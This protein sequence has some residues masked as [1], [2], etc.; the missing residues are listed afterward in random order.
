MAIQMVPWRARHA[1]GRADAARGRVAPP[2]D[3]RR[4]MAG[5]RGKEWII[6]ATICAWTN[7]AG[8]GTGVAEVLQS[9]AGESGRYRFARRRTG[10]LSA[11]RSAGAA[12]AADLGRRLTAGV[13]AQESLSLWRE[14]YQIA[15]ERGRGLRLRLHIDSW[16][17]ARLP[18]E[19]LYDTRRGDFYVFD[20]MISLVRYVRLPAAPP[21]LRQSRTLKVLARWPRPSTSRPSIGT[22]V[23][24]PA[25]CPARS[26]RRRTGGAGHLLTPHPGTPAPGPGRAHAGRD[27]L[28]RPRRISAGSAPGPADAGE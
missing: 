7:G 22:R 16:D 1:A 20:P 24:L 23:G 4:P 25:R 8:R 3:G 27:P 17:L 2:V 18:W 5:H 14:S 26:R 21:A 6:S 19:L 9:P 10:P 12:L 11:P 13:L 28:Y 15:R